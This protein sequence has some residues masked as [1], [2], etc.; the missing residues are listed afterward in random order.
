MSSMQT[1]PDADCDGAAGPGAGEAG[2]VEQGPYKLELLGGGWAAAIGHVEKGTIS[3]KPSAPGGLKFTRIDLDAF[4]LGHTAAVL[5]MQGMR[6]QDL[7]PADAYFEY[8]SAA[9]RVV[10]ACGPFVFLKGTLSESWDPP[11]RLQGAVLAALEHVP[12]DLTRDEVLT[13]LLKEVV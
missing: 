4:V 8:T 10:L 2:G 9:Q 7:F 1:L 3:R 11:L 6:L 5:V 13:L 12:P